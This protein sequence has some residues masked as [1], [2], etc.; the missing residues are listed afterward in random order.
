ML[1][2]RCNL[3]VDCLDRSA[4]GTGQSHGRS[5]FLKRSVNESSGHTIDISGRLGVGEGLVSSSLLQAVDVRD[6]TRTSGGS[7][8]TKKTKDWVLD[9]GR[10]VGG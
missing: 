5:V 2:N 10:V 3:S 1:G 9:A 8:G 7:C 6:S 4:S